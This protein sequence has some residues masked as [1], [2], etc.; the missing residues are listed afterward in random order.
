M[1]GDLYLAQ[2][3]NSGFTLD[4]SR[5]NTPV[6]IFAH[7][8]C[9]DDAGANSMTTDMRGKSDLFGAIACQR[10]LSAIT[11]L[12]AKPVIRVSSG[13]FVCRLSF[14]SKPGFVARRWLPG[15]ASRPPFSSLKSEISK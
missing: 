12:P 10:R 11:M 15:T 8:A 3:R 6:G 5:L 14:G 4:G 1:A 2:P 13:Y 9:G 7:R